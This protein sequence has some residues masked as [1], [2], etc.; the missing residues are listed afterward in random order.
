LFAWESLE[1]NAHL[2]IDF[3]RPYE[4]MGTPVHIEPNGNGAVSLRAIPGM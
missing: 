2:N 3:M 1:P 4:S